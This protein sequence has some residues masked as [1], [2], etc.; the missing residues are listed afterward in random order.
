MVQFFQDIAG[1]FK[2]LHFEYTEQFL[3]ALIPMAVTVFLH[4]QGMGLVR[5]CMK[6]FA[7]HPAG[8][9]RNRV[10]LHMLIL[11]VAIILATHFS[12]VVA[13]AIFY[14]LMGVLPDTRTAMYF[15]IN[16]Y[17]TLGASNITLPGRWMGM[18]GFEAMTA[19][20]MFG[21]S[22]AAL[23]VVLQKLHSFDD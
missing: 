17:T 13:W 10:H 2:E 1:I 8:N 23:A 12:E 7:P 20:L 4:G 16:A 14:G 18:D 19:M 15:S 11:I 3:M 5:R 6:R 21:W 9:P 22:T